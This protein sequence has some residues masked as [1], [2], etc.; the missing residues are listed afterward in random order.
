MLNKGLNKDAQDTKYGR[1]PLHYAARAGHGAVVRTLMTNGA[2]GNVADKAG[3][4][5]I[6]LAAEGGH[7]GLMTAMKHFRSAM[8]S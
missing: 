3:K 6:Q 1:T 8:E 7:R 2:N 5:P 4:T